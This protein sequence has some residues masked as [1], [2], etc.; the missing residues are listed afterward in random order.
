MSGPYDDV[1]DRLEAI[2]ADLDER[3]FDLLREAAA[4]RGGRPAD[5]KRIMQ[6]RRSIEKAIHV[7]RATGADREVDE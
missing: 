2:V 1:A 3:S 5:D 4:A 6:A 7:L